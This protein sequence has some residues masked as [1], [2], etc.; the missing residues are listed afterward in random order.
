VVQLFMSVDKV[1][2]INVVDNKGTIS[3]R[4]K[5]FI[6]PT[7]ILCDF[8]SLISNIEQIDLLKVFL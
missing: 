8:D 7:L 1:I 5:Y 3:N 2:L 6:G 4:F